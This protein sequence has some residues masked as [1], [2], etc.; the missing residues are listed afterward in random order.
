M[1][2]WFVVRVSTRWPGQH[3]MMARGQLTSWQLQVR[4]TLGWHIDSADDDTDKDGGDDDYHLKPWFK[5]CTYALAAILIWAKG[6]LWVTNREQKDSSATVWNNGLPWHVEVT[7]VCEC[8][9][10]WKHSTFHVTIVS[11]FVFRLS[12]FQAF[13]SWNKTK[14]T[15]SSSINTMI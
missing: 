8:V 12:L 5:M 2:A 14:F 7:D 10:N 11:T 3:C 15:F 9:W 1:C 13:E 4:Q 6:G